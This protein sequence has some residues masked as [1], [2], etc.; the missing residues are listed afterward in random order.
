MTHFNCLCFSFSK[1]FSGASHSNDARARAVKINH[2]HK[3]LQCE[4]VILI[5][6][7]LEVLMGESMNLI[8]FILTRLWEYR[9]CQK[10]IDHF[11]IFWE[12]TLKRYKNIS[13]SII[14]NNTD[15]L[16]MDMVENP[17]MTFKINGHFTVIIQN[18]FFHRILIN[19]ITYQYTAQWTDNSPETEKGA[20]KIN[21][22]KIEYSKIN[23]RNCLRR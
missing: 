21:D 15:V 7:F 8:K 1:L 12:W 19:C 6:R 14:S 16:L 22:L 18:V 2:K 4:Q 11:V 3:I 9:W 13:I 10:V 5:V 20:K 17:R 23:E